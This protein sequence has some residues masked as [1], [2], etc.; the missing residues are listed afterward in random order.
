ME[1]MPSQLFSMRIVTSDSNISHAWS[2][3]VDM[4]T[5][6]EIG[7]VKEWPES[8]EALLLSRSIIT[9]TS[10][11]E[12]TISVK[13]FG[14][15]EKA[16]LRPSQA[17]KV[18]LGDLWEIY[19]S[20]SKDF[21]EHAVP[22]ASI[23][24]SMEQAVQWEEQPQKESTIERVIALD[25]GLLNNTSMIKLCNAQESNSEEEDSTNHHWRI[26]GLMRFYLPTRER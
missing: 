20:Y 14:W 2:L 8:Y 10:L 4:L 6:G 12:N 3:L 24:R 26:R 5:Q 25:E 9:I 19:R 18:L 22:K 15:F 23:R 17:K 21:L 16:Q 13:I 1:Y 7:Y 11:G